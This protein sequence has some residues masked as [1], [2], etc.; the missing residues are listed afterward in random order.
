MKVRALRV[1]A[2]TA[3][4]WALVSAGVAC[5]GQP[6]DTAPPGTVTL[7]PFRVTP[8]LIVKDMGV[9]DNVFNESVNPKRDYTV[10]VTPR[11]DVAFRMRRLRLGYSTATEYVYYRTYRSERGTNTSSLARMDVD[12]GYLKPYA[13]IQGVN[14]RARLNSEIDARAR[15]R[16]LLYGAGIA[17][18]I[19]SRTSLLVNGT[20]GKVAYDPD[21][22]K[23]RGVDLRQSFDGRRRS[24]DVGIGIALTPLTTFTMVVAREQQRFALSSARDSNAWRVSPTVSFSPSGLLTGSAT[25]GY[26][27]FHTLSASLADFSGLVSLVNVGATIY[28]RHQ[29]DARFSRDVQYSYDV[30][31]AYYLGTGGTVTWTYLLAGPID[32]RGVVGRNQNDY[33]VAGDALGHERLTTYGG[34]V[35]YRFSNRARLGVNADWSRRESTKSAERNYRNHRIFAGLT[36]GTTP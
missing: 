2:A 31:T 28:G 12:L 17:L 3:V 15:H 8:S 6:P 10:T 4:A 26:R 5:A 33:T 25:V 1:I 29:V 13:T 7:G 34:G 36:W 18:K 24:I 32:V 14:T 23:F 27:R 9:D 21:A 19:A 30:A 35:G 22:E 20:Q 16:D 11:A